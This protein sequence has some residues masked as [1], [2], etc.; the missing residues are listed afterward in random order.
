MRTMNFT[1]LLHTCVS[2]MLPARCAACEKAEASYPL[3][4]CGHCEAEMTQ[5][6]S[7]QPYSTGNIT[8]I[9]SCRKNAGAVRKCLHLFKYEGHMNLLSVF[10]EI[11]GSSLSENNYLQNFADIVIPVPAHPFKRHKR[12][13][14]QAESLSS[15]LSSY[16]S[17]SL[18]PRVLIK[19]RNTPPQM[20]LTKSERINNVKG[21]FKVIDKFQV[22]G[23]RILLVDDI[24][25][26]G[27]TLDECAREL[28]RAGAGEVWAFTLARTPLK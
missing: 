20:R 5:N 25:T 3:P 26:T 6:P 8:R 12:G 22:I 14:N 17:C 4:I 18:R 13:F 19:T 21:A 27:A 28:L 1:N 16:L 15:I 7:L 23:K 10:E 11:I 9:Y 24:V 2:V